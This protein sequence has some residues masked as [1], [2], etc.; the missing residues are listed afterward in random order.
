MTI[1]VSRSLRI[2][3]P[4]LDAEDL[5]IHF[6]NTMAWRLRDPPEERLTSPFALLDWFGASGISDPK[7]T[8]AIS[9]S[10]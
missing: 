6:V 1:S 7:E 5:A 9:R 10:W 2:P 8:K 3:K 4:G